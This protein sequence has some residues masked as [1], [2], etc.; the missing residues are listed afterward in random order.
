MEGNMKMKRLTTV[1]R[2][3]SSHTN[4]KVMLSRDDLVDEDEQHHIMNFWMKYTDSRNMSD[5]RFKSFFNESLLGE[6]MIKEESDPIQSL[7][8]VYIFESYE[9]DGIVYKQK[10]PF[11]KFALKL[12]YEVRMESR[13]RYV[14]KK[15]KKM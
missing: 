10:D 6:L 15:T 9:R 14:S 12:A 11:F 8:G 7:C 5:E 2:E 3:Q 1:K 4:Q 13:F